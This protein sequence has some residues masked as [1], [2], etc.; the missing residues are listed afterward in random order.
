[1]KSQQPAIAAIDGMKPA[2]AVF[3][4]RAMMPAPTV[5]PAMRNVAPNTRS[6]GGSSFIISSDTTDTCSRMS[7]YSF[8]AGICNPSAPAL[9]TIFGP[10]ACIQYPWVA[11]TCADVARRMDRS[12]MRSSL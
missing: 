1:M 10:P 9:K 5:P 4:G 8:C 7:L 12:S 6:A 11:T 3:T 2:A